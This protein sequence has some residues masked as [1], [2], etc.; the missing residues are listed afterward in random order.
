MTKTNREKGEEILKKRR[1]AAKGLKEQP[2]GR[3]IDPMEDFNPLGETIVDTNEA[4]V[5]RTK[6][7]AVAGIVTRRSG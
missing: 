6:Q 1:L 4:Q 3:A 2:D 7:A 5:G